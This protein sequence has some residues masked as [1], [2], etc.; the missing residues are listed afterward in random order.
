MASPKTVAKTTTLQQRDRRGITDGADGPVWWC[1]AVVR[2]MARWEWTWTLYANV[3][4]S[5]ATEA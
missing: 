3:S 4:A 5:W 1:P 2:G